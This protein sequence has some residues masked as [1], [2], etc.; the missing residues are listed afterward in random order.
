MR[1]KS[2]RI[3]NYKTLKDIELQD[4]RNFGIIIGQNMSGKSN[5]FEAM[6][7][8]HDAAD[9]LLEDLFR[10]KISFCDIVWRKM[11][12]E[13]IL[14]MI[15]IELDENRRDELLKKAIG[16]KKDDRQERIYDSY[17]LQCL[18]YELVINMSDNPKYTEVLKTDNVDDIDRQVIFIS[19]ILQEQTRKVLTRVNNIQNSL[20]SVLQGQ[21]FNNNLSTKGNP[22]TFPQLRLFFDHERS[23]S[24]ASL[25]EEIINMAGDFFK[26]FKW[27]GPSRKVKDFSE[28]SGS[29]NINIDAS[30]L[31]EVLNTIR[32][33]E[34][35]QFDTLEKYISELI[36]NIEHLL[37]PV[38]QGKT[39][40]G[41][42]EKGQ[43]SSIIY[44]LRNI[45]AG[46]KN[47]LSLLAFLYT[48]E[49]AS[50]LFIE[51]PE[52]NLH[53]RA[54]RLLCNIIRGQSKN[55][56]ILITTHSPTA[57]LG[58]SIDNIYLCKR[59]RDGNSTVSKVTS[60]DAQK[61]IEELGICPSDFLDHALI[62]FVEG[63]Y[64]VEIYKT[65]AKKTNFNSEDI[66]YIPTDGWK[67][68]D[69][70][71]NA[72]VLEKRNVCPKIIAIFDG[73]TEQNRHEKN[74]MLHRM[75][76]RKENIITLT[77]KEIECYLLD[78]DAWFKTFPQLGISKD[79][80]NSLFEQIE[81]N[82][83]P[84]E[85]MDKIMVD[86]GIGPY[87]KEKAVQIAEKMETTPNEIKQILERI[88]VVKNS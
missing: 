11:L 20:S 79:K 12:N 66:C 7:F 86:L 82:D 41:L 48:S 5:V 35:T 52:N 19:K 71:A 64:D 31:S 42:H 30:N 57:L 80:L 9:K 37:T 51:E 60:D 81:N 44:D 18:Y 25:D 67:N 85:Q 53:A 13:N 56:Q 28:I 6:K 74:R 68:M 62:V 15:Q 38:S 58:F 43:E 61:I 78:A 75:H 33:N 17:F 22:Y 34:L 72:S 24:P 39:T 8:L 76:V 59:D 83:K 70:H 32:N 46:T 49:E 45:S 84:K 77:K 1:I 73:D 16:D 54:L 4:L 14:F 29:R 2:I 26:K 69:Y 3:Q 88:R 21:A 36:P 87:T 10:E 40:I 55:K 65:F 23:Y 63:E 27:L 47:L 50:V